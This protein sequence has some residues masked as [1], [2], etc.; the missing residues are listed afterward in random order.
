MNFE[1]IFFLDLIY[2]DVYISIDDAHQIHDYNH[3]VLLYPL[4]VPLFT[5]KTK[6]VYTAHQTSARQSRVRRLLSLHTSFNL[7]SSSRRHLIQRSITYFLGLVVPIPDL[8]LLQ[9]LDVYE[10]SN[11]IG[12]FIV[13]S[14]REPSEVPP[15]ELKKVR[16]TKPMLRQ[17]VRVF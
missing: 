13:S 12:R 10:K 2:S 17:R 6:M 15:P 8:L 16:M 11:K 3:V 9:L 4:P 1:G 14:G 7:I 5:S